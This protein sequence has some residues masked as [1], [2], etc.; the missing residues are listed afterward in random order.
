MEIDAA[1]KQGGRVG[2]LVT[3]SPNTPLTPLPSADA[4]AIDSLHLTSAMSEQQSIQQITATE[5]AG[6]LRQ[7]SVR[8]HRRVCMSL[9]VCPG[10]TRYVTTIA[11]CSP[12]VR[13]SRALKRTQHRGRRREARSRMKERRRTMEFV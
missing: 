11:R 7:H 3:K 4:C 10:R 2:G 5:A 8:L 6:G 9:F 13:P 12:P 1:L